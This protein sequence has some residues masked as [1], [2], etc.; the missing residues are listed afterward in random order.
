VHPTDKGGFWDIGGFPSNNID[1]PTQPNIDN[2]WLFAS[3]SRMA[4]FDQKFYF[5]LNVAVGI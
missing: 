3:N 2:P 4:P 5:V 1:N